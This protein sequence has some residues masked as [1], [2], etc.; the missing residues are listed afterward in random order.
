[1]TARRPRA[2]SRRFFRG[3]LLTVAVVVSA[4]ALTPPGPPDTSGFLTQAP[5]F[6]PVAGG[7]GDPRGL[8]A[9]PDPAATKILIYS[10]GTTRPHRREDCRLPD[11]AVP[12]LLLRL[13]T[14]PGWAVY[15]L[16]SS[17][18]DAGETGSYIGKRKAEILALLD[19]MRT[20]GIPPEH[21]F[22][23][24]HSAGAWSTLMAMGAQGRAFNAAVVFAPACCG[25]RSE[26]AVFPVWRETIR[27]AQVARMTAT[28]RSE[29]LV[30]AF[31]DDAFNRP[32]DLAFLREAYPRNVRIVVPD[33]GTGHQSHLGSCADDPALEALIEGYLAARLKASGS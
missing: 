32:E 13:G 1:M 28:G 22:L 29:A 11:N 7:A 19:R 5:G 17:A 6:A 15:Y 4:C 26:R 2:D 21:I 20:A 12:P 10:H 27:P 33:C 24:G 8:I 18:T 30:I 9:L 23:S 3:W 16:C 31:P 14:R 25:P